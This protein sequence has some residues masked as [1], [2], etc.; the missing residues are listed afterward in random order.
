M[1]IRKWARTI[2][3]TALTAG[4]ITGAAAS[5]G[6]DKRFDES[7]YRHDVME[8]AKYSMGNIMQLV[9]GQAKHEGHLAKLAEILAIS[10]S[11]TKES[12]AKDTRGM[13]GHTEAKDAIWENWDDFASRSDTYAADTAAFAAAAKTGDQGAT[14]AA[15]KKAASNC[16]SCHDKYKDD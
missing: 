5:H 9:K 16:K 11:M 1:T 14:M 3:V 12:F 15:F 13:E 6:A 7:Q 8:H 10:A 2:S 4:L